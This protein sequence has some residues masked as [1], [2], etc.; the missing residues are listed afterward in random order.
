[1]KRI[2][3]S[4]TVCIFVSNGVCGLIPKLNP[5]TERYAFVTEVKKKYS[6]PM[7]AEENASLL[8]FIKAIAEPVQ[9]QKKTLQDALLNCF[10]EAESDEVKKH[11]QTFR[12][13]LIKVNSD[14][15][16]S[17][18]ARQAA[19]EEFEREVG[20]EFVNSL[21]KLVSRN[22]EDSLTN[23]AQSFVRYESRVAK[24]KLGAV[25][26]DLLTDIKTRGFGFRLGN[27]RTYSDAEKN[28]VKENLHHIHH[29]NFI[30]SLNLSGFGLAELPDNLIELKSLNV[31]QLQQNEFTTVPH[32]VTALQAQNTIL[33]EISENKIPAHDLDTVLRRCAEVIWEGN[34]HS[35]IKL[36]EIQWNDIMPVVTQAGSKLTVER[37]AFAPL[38]EIMACS[39]AED[40][41]AACDAWYKNPVNIARL[42]RLNSQFS[43]P[44]AAHFIANFPNQVFVEKIGGF[45][46]SQF[47]F[48]V[49][50][51]IVEYLSS[52][53]LIAING[54]VTDSDGEKTFIPKNVAGWKRY[55][56]ADPIH[57][58]EKAWFTPEGV[59]ALF[60]CLEVIDRPCG[61]EMIPI[62]IKKL[63]A[64][65]KETNMPFLIS[66]DIRFFDT[67]GLRRQE[68]G[69]VSRTL[70]SHEKAWIKEYKHRFPELPFLKGINLAELELTDAPDHYETF[71]DLNILFLYKNNVTEITPK[72]RMLFEKFPELTIDLQKNPVMSGYEQLRTR[73]FMAYSDF[74]A[75]HGEPPET[76]KTAILEY[77]AIGVHNEA[78]V[79]LSDTEREWVKERIAH[80]H[81]LNFLTG[82]N[83]SNMNLTD[84]PDTFAEFAS[85]DMIYLRDNNLDRA[86]RVLAKLLA[87]KPSCRIEVDQKIEDGGFN[88]LL[89]RQKQLHQ[90]RLQKETLDREKQRIKRF[91]DRLVKPDLD[92]KTLKWDP[93][94]VA[95]LGLGELTEQS[96]TYVPD[97]F[98]TNVRDAE[99]FESLELKQKLKSK[100]LTQH[101]RKEY[102][103]ELLK[104]NKNIQG[105][106][107]KLDEHEA[108]FKK[109]MWKYHHCF[110]EFFLRRAEEL[111]L[112][113]KKGEPT[114]TNG[115][116]LPDLAKLE[117]SNSAWL[118]DP[119]NRNML[120]LFMS[121][122]TPQDFMKAFIEKST[123]LSEMLAIKHSQE[124]AR[125]EMA[126][127]ID[128]KRAEGVDKEE[129]K[130]YA[131]I[132]STF[133]DESKGLS[134]KSLEER[135]Q[136]LRYILVTSLGVDGKFIPYFK[137]KN[138][139]VGKELKYHGWKS[140]FT[141][142]PDLNKKYQGWY[143]DLG[144]AELLTFLKLAVPSHEDDIDHDGDEDDQ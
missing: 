10:S 110:F 125:S 127:F 39:L 54:E 23:A 9:V 129:F 24:E 19:L 36:D 7:S 30:C 101:Q 86:P 56:T 51:L 4:F 6:P 114:D 117:E 75:A 53:D 22:S 60:N 32:V 112:T 61:I 15:Y 16:N 41:Q 52:S 73:K 96:V 115:E 89:T 11:I 133:R 70:S 90:E 139:G 130:D 58:A 107:K 46:P 123:Y 62:D 82:L 55:F 122:Y 103:A 2:I 124:S 63:K 78:P 113:I 69:I 45:E 29:L 119:I 3:L 84:L 121:M 94:F 109:N 134:L 128:Q 131:E 25:P 14:K 44:E 132:Y 8:R 120:Y 81:K 13:T 31:L 143:L 77:D 141:E 138:S 111:Q 12:N 98:W 105:A 5:W 68:Y 1:M 137:T 33:V 95:S 92:P 48:M 67:I 21:Q 65:Q 142:V 37:Y 57:D 64:F 106:Q 47:K 59:Q 28:F 74:V 88:K 49:K 140:Y 116:S 72:M 93:S 80:L 85:L 144:I 100:T 79:K 99:L 87:R 91:L 26:Q 17:E 43:A 76:L 135:T 118:D 83:L 102:Q 38:V 42:K 108:Q 20:E 27:A 34:I 126:A 71:N 35:L 97:A 40:A 136:A 104:I 66:E 18:N 50:N